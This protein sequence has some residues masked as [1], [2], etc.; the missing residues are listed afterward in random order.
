M[1]NAALQPFGCAQLNARRVHMPCLIMHAFQYPSYRKK[2]SDVTP[3]LRDRWRPTDYRVLN[4]TAHFHSREKELP[5]E[6]SFNFRAAASSCSPLHGLH[7]V[8]LN[9]ASGSL[10]SYA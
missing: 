8:T 7:I 10:Y 6:I 9:R 2:R 1:H 4:N 3:F 5:L